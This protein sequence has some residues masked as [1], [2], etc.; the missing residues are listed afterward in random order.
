MS[1]QT[2]P[3]VFISH[4]L[5]NRTIWGLI[6]GYSFNRLLAWIQHNKQHNPHKHDKECI[7]FGIELGGT[8]CKVG[9]AKVKY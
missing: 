3:C 4:F 5:N 8:T 6:I 9:K 7:H 1:K 2:H